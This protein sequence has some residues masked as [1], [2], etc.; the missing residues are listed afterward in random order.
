MAEIRPAAER[1]RAFF[2][3]LGYV[4]SLEVHQA[5]EED[6]LVAMGLVEK[7]TRSRKLK[8]TGFERKN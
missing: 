5:R 4:F 7:W 1:W 3:A 8:A 6:T 2:C